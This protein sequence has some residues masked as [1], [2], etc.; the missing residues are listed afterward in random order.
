MLFRSLGLQGGVVIANPVPEADAMPEAEIEA[1]TNQALAEAEQQG[2]GGKAV[3]P[4]LLARIKE[5]TA[6]RSLTTNIAL[7]KNNAVCGAR[8]AA[9][10][11]QI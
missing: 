9:A 7:V 1:M 8:L 6:G 10:L 2:I 5:L 11:K 3:T 4:F